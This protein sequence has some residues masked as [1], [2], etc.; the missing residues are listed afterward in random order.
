MTIRERKLFKIV[1]RGVLF[2][3]SVTYAEWI[4]AL[5]ELLSLPKETE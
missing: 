4:A 1:M 3:A 5:D 2:K